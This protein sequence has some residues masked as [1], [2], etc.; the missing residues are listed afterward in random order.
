MLSRMLKVCDYCP[1]ALAPLIHYTGPFPSRFS[2]SPHWPVRQKRRGR[3]GLPAVNF[4]RAAALNYSAL[5]GNVSL[6]TNGLLKS[7]LCACYL[8]PSEAI[9]PSHLYQGVM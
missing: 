5:A 2:F 6:S 9:L 3:G 1:I 7:K 4:E 8:C